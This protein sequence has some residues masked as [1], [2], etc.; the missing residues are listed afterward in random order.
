MFGYRFLMTNRSYKTGTAREQL[1]LLPPRIEDY[2]SPDALV[3][4]IDAYVDTLDLTE[5][6][7][8]YTDGGHANGNGQPPYDPR[9]NL[10]LYLAPRRIEWV[11]HSFVSG[12]RAA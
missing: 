7:F 6:G 1:S 8:R 5:L 9:D 2:V 10:K 3:R 4:A 12:R 11:D